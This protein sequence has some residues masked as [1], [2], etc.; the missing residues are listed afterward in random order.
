MPKPHD[1]FPCHRT[2]LSLNPL[3]YQFFTQKMVSRSIHNIKIDTIYMYD[4]PFD[5]PF[6]QL[7]NGIRRHA[8]YWHKARINSKD[9]DGSARLTAGC[10][11]QWVNQPLWCHPCVVVGTD[12]TTWSS[13]TWIVTGLS[14]RRHR[15]TPSPISVGKFCCKKDTETGFAPS[16][17]YQLWGSFNQC[18]SLAYKANRNQV[19]T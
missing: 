6:L 15:F 8:I 3:A 16:I 1:C 18:C 14:Y 9:I 4:I 5:R 2:S 12:F 7:S 13:V 19:H 10:V 11:C 17:L